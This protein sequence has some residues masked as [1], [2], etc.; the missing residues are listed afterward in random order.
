MVLPSR[1]EVVLDNNPEAGCRVMGR[2]QSLGFRCFLGLRDL[3]F[4][5]PGFFK[6]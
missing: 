6:V 3:W 5:V 2:R 4:R 1:G